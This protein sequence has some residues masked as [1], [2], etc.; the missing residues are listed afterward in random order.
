MNKFKIYNNKIIILLIM[1]ILSLVFWYK[2]FFWIDYSDDKNKFENYIIWTWNIIEHIKVVWRAELVNEQKLR[3]NQIWKVAKVN[4]KNWDKV[5][6]WNI[7]AELDKIDLDNQIKQAE[8]NLQ[9]SQLTLQQLL[10]WKD[11]SIITKA[12]NDISNTQKKII[13]AQKNV[14]IALSD[15]NTT[16]KSLD[17]EVSLAR[18]DVKNKQ[19]SLEKAN[20]DLENTKK[21]EEKNISN[22]TN[23]Y[24]STLQDSLISLKDELIKSDSILKNLNDILWIEKWFEDVNDTFEWNLWTLDLSTFSKAKGSYRNAKTNKDNLE[25]IY[26]SLINKNDLNIQDVTWILWKAKTGFS[27]ILSATDDTYKM[28][29][30]STT[31]NWY[32]LAQLNT[33]K[34]T[35]SSDRQTA[36]KSLDS[37]S[38]QLL[39]VKNLSD[40]SLSSLNS[41]QTIAQKEENVRN[42]IS[43]L[44]KAQDILNNLEDT[45]SLK[46]ENKNI[47]L[48]QANNDLQNLQDTLKAQQQTLSEL[49]R[50]ETKQT[51]EKAKNDITQKKLALENIKENKDKYELSAPF[52]WTIR[53][54]DFQV[55]DNLIVDDTKYVYLENPELLKVTIT[56]DQIDIVKVKLWQKAILYLM[57]SL[58]KNLLEQLMKLI[59]CQ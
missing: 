18:Q 19:A 24:S 22:S 25:N 7:I 5:T 53:K 10:S 6:K 13:T 3:F 11:A 56:L 45:L 57:H 58:T 23:T 50:W 41:T 47:M 37:I 51:I 42:A 8:L 38:S 40:T 48:T 33:H 43:S 55:W 16:Y 35:I 36:Q 9:N 2:Y 1:T 31:W 54:I 4:F 52:D 49:Q 21:L 28:L 20:S 39:S 44:N 14:E 17:N 30:N 34:S 26:E 12:K 29:L 46:K 32:S 59:P 15:K 27:N